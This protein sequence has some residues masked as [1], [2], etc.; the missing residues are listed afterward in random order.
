MLKICKR[1]RLLRLKILSA[2]G[3]REISLYVIVH[4]FLHC[5]PPITVSLIFFPCLL[6]CVLGSYLAYLKNDSRIVESE[7]RY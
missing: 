5:L 2:V 3:D 4:T 1:C 7:S 6:Y